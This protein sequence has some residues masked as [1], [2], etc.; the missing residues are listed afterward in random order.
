MMVQ[1]SLAPRRRTT[2]TQFLETLA[3]AIHDTNS[4]E[5]PSTELV[6]VLLRRPRLLDAP[7]DLEV[8]ATIVAAARTLSARGVRVDLEIPKRGKR[9]GPARLEWL[10]TLRKSGIESLLLHSQMSERVT[11][12]G[13][14]LPYFGTV[15]GP[16]TTRV[17]PLRWVDSTTFVRFDVTV[18][19]QRD[20]ETRTRPKWSPSEQLRNEIS[21]TLIAQ[22]W[23]PSDCHRVVD[24][25]VG[26]VGGNVLEHADSAAGLGIGILGGTIAD[27]TKGTGVCDL[28]VIDLGRGFVGSR[29]ARYLEH[30]AMASS[31]VAAERELIRELRSGTHVSF[32]DEGPRS[33][34]YKHGMHFLSDNLVGTE[35]I[36]IRGAYAQVILARQE[37]AVVERAEQAPAEAS[38][39]VT[40]RLR[41][42]P[43]RSR[44]TV[45]GLEAL[46]TSDL[47]GSLDRTPSIDLGAFAVV[48]PD[49]LRSYVSAENSPA[50]GGVQFVVTDLGFEDRFRKHGLASLLASVQGIDGLVLMNVPADKDDL[51][52]LQRTESGGNP[53]FIAVADYETC[54]LVAPSARAQKS[55]A[56]PTSLASCF[57]VPEGELPIAS[58]AMLRLRIAD[59]RVLCTACN[60]AF[61]EAHLSGTAPS[62]G[63]YPLA[64]SV[65]L[66]GGKAG[67]FF[68][69]RQACNSPTQRRRW[70]STARVLLREALLDLQTRSK[71][72]LSP[73]AVRVLGYSSSVA[74]LL[75]DA[76][77]VEGLPFECK[78]VP[79]S[80]EQSI[81]RAL[82]SVA[83]GTT[84]LLF[85][86]VVRSGSLRNQVIAMVSNLN[87]SVEL[88]SIALVRDQYAQ[89]PL[90]ITSELPHVKE[91][92]GASIRFA[93]TSTMSADF[94]LDPHSLIPN[95]LERPDQA[96]SRR[97]DATLT[98]LAGV[99]HAISQAHTRHGARHEVISVNVEAI[100]GDDAVGV[101][102]QRSVVDAIKARL[103]ERDRWFSFG[104]D[105]PS[106]QSLAPRA[107]VYPL[108]PD[109]PAADI[110][111]PTSA[112]EPFIRSFALGI[113]A[114]FQNR[115][116]V[117]PVPIGVPRAWDADGRALVFHEHLTDDLRKLLP[118]TLVRRDILIVDDGVWTGAT[119]RQLLQFAAD[120]G[121]SRAVIVAA[122]SRL[123]LDDMRWWE[124]LAEIRI[125]GEAKPMRIAAVFPYHLPIPCLTHDT[126]PQERL[127]KRL[128]PLAIQHPTLAPVIQ[129][130]LAEYRDG[131]DRAPPSRAALVA[132]VA[133]LTLCDH[134]PGW[135]RALAESVDSTEDI[136]L[137]HSFLLAPHLAHS[138]RLRDGV[139]HR[140]LSRCAAGI[141][142]GQTEAS[143]AERF[144][145][146]ARLA[147]LPDLL[148]IINASRE[149][150]LEYS[151]TAL[152]RLCIHALSADKLAPSRHALIESTLQLVS[153]WH[154]E[155]AQYRSSR[156]F[157]DE[158]KSILTAELAALPVRL[159]P[160]QVT[161]AIQ[162]F[163][164]DPRL[165]NITSV[166][167]HKIIERKDTHR[168]N[169]LTFLEVAELVL[170]ERDPL[171]R[172][173][174]EALK[175]RT[176]CDEILSYVD[177]L[178]RMDA[179][180]ADERE[181]TSSEPFRERI[182]RAI[183]LHSAAIVRVASDLDLM[184]TRFS[185]GD[186]LR[187]A[188]GYSGPVAA[189]DT[190]TLIALPEGLYL[191]ISDGIRRLTSTQQ[192]RSGDGTPWHEVRLEN[193][194]AS[195]FG[196]CNV[197][198]SFRYPT[199]GVTELAVDLAEHASVP[200]SRLGGVLRVTGGAI[201][202]VL[203][204]HLTLPVARTLQA[205]A[206]TTF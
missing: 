110:N 56:A 122:L 131:S 189:S 75:R 188:G 85:T 151:P 67:D 58:T 172:I 10:H 84:L 96:T 76:V 158:L 8:L 69:L 112:Q 192:A 197:T 180:F 18:E 183:G 2:W 113:A 103:Q 7:P 163:L 168:R 34:Y 73:N 117:S 68:S 152:A 128:R 1:L 43:A 105:E 199:R 146:A 70:L 36:C 97:I 179:A 44:Q 141:R 14:P 86:D 28:F 72:R 125:D 52:R 49:D 91:W 148:A 79:D 171:W 196:Y 201:S 51:S 182:L 191:T 123:P 205:H 107:V 154:G 9:E 5:A 53:W 145:A 23:S 140:F 15:T 12:S 111:S 50:G 190:E 121:A 100:L 138:P 88:L 202:S 32:V 144:A 198:C 104:D 109:A 150:R 116:G 35:H 21:D 33:A 174:Q 13:T 135:Y 115:S 37:S 160:L 31:A 133:K 170:S 142:G 60:S 57:A 143:V 82:K 167:L 93:Y 176:A 59:Y 95:R 99:P 173:G 92:I 42:T 3:A 40:V 187:E 83:P 139:Y 45:L 17:L 193:V 30:L 165:A 64:S 77:K 147:S 29:R 55:R 186:F 38:P 63:V 200:L 81:G 134:S 149:C 161:R 4:P 195:A 181:R 98:L 132:A 46:D 119:C 106:W 26:E 153:E 102:A 203:T 155:S 108:P 47:V 204:L 136:L 175:L 162:T 166:R 129:D 120:A 61:L 22:G 89:E 126:C 20:G 101:E 156:S 159:H 71:G 114:F 124:G 66:P 16:E 39:G 19:I 25:F 78:V 41:I 6:R 80:S 48:S 62:D 130:L 164:Q 54:L 184:L 185:I 65:L 74:E 206:T 178:A 87:R 169:L 94:A 194:P 127:D 27:G 157:I 11:L 137:A 177:S 118:R 24:H 90:P